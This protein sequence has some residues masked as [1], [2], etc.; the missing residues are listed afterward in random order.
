MDN[1][2]VEICGFLND[3]PFAYSAT[4]D[5]GT[6]DCLANALPVHEAFDFPGHVNVVA[7]RLRRAWRSP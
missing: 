7:G 3:A 1:C 6:V 5:E 4:Y 2:S